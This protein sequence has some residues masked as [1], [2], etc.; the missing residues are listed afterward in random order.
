M[1]EF[2]FKNMT[3]NEIMLEMKKMENSYEKTKIDISALID[4]MKSL[5]ESYIKAKKEL[6][7]RSK[8]I[9]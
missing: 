9:I 5:D 7:N 2:D 6:E 3:N 1:I 4:K 8:G